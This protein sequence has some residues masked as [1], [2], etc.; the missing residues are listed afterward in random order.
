[1][2]PSIEEVNSIII[3]TLKKSI[4]DIIPTIPRLS[5]TLMEE[6]SALLARMLVEKRKLAE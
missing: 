6:E 2:V 5:K 1:M 3:E 4:Y